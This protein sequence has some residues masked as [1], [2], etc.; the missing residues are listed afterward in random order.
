MSK[1]FYRY[2][3]GLQQEGEGDERFR[4]F[5]PENYEFKAHFE[6]DNGESFD[7]HSPV[8]PSGTYTDNDLV[9][10]NHITLTQLWTTYWDWRDQ[11]QQIVGFE[12]NGDPEG[13]HSRVSQ[14]V[15][16][17]IDSSLKS[18]PWLEIR[19]VEGN[20]RQVIVHLEEPVR[21]TSREESAALRVAVM[22]LVSQETGFEFDDYLK[23]LE[24]DYQVQ[25]YGFLDT[26][27]DAFQVLKQATV[28]LPLT[29]LSLEW[30]APALVTT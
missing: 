13:N 15:L 11:S 5:V 24:E 26:D 25:I 1:S 12:I 23:E 4:S 9:V 20:W 3:K 7:Y 27:K 30:L 18:V 28:T 17:R 21:V 22:S 2:L 16:T 6:E 8:R 19:S 29:E 10:C 14:D